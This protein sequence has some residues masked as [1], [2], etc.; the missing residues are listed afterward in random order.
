MVDSAVKFISENTDY[1]T[2]RRLANPKDGEVVGDF[3]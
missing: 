1:D 2:I 3:E